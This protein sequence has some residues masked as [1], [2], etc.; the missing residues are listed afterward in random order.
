MGRET[1]TAAQLRAM[2]Q[3]RIDALPEVVE[4]AQRRGG[5]GLV[6]GPVERLDAGAPGAN[7][8]IRSITGGIGY[9]SLLRG[10]VDALRSRY[11]LAD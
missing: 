9:T 6:V 4:L 3:V 2:A 1:R 7:W 5:A 11:D 10:V 8:D